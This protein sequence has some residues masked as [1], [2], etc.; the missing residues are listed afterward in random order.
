M[1]ARP[2]LGST[3]TKLITLVME[4]K[5][6][7]VRIIR[8]CTFPTVRRLLSYTQ[9][10]RAHFIISQNSPN[11]YGTCYAFEKLPSEKDLVISEDCHSFTWHFKGGY[12]GMGVR[13][14]CKLLSFVEEFPLHLQLTLFFSANP[15]TGQPGY[16]ES[17]SG[18]FIN[19]AEKTSNR[20]PFHD[21]KYPNFSKANS[22]TKGWSPDLPKRLGIPKSKIGHPK[23][24]RPCEI[25]GDPGEAPGTP[26]NY[27]PARAAQY[28]KFEP[29]ESPNWPKC[30]KGPNGKII[31]TNSHP[32]SKGSKYCQQSPD[33]ETCNS[34]EKSLPPPKANC[35]DDPNAEGCQSS[36]SKSVG[37]NSDS[38]TKPKCDKNPDA[39]GC[40]NDSS[41][42]AKKST[43]ENSKKT[44]QKKV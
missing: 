36:G 14:I 10:A 5:C 25:N 20:Q 12:P 21:A 2:R 9:P 7:S 27:K 41:S 13:E 40:V 26:G 22:S 35:V 3:K 1:F 17:L 37:E 30:H 11:P 44:F 15:Q 23:C 42:A 24:G 32:Q 4:Y 31:Y 16:E 8:V 6:Q 43:K 29:L 28:T 18:K 39:E 33:S 38:S 34:S 19:G